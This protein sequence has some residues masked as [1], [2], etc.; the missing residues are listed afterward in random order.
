MRKVGGEFA[1]VC[2][3]RQRYFSPKEAHQGKVGFEGDIPKCQRVTC[4]CTTK[5][6]Y[7]D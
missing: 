3:I 5:S 7:R 6:E 2:V 1:C 4:A